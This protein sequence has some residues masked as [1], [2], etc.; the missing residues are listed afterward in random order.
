LKKWM[1]SRSWKRE[2]R[3]IGR[4]KD[5]SNKE[6]TYIIIKRIIIHSTPIY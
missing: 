6:S 4:S 5:Q 2:S 1:G 3:S